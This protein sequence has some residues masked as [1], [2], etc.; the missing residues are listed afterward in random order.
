MTSTIEGE[1]GGL[2]APLLSPRDNAATSPPTQ[3]A[4]G[5]AFNSWA[6]FG[7]FGGLR[8][9]TAKTPNNGAKAQP[10]DNADAAATEAVAPEATSSSQLDS[11]SALALPAPPAGSGIRGGA[12]AGSSS[13]A[14]RE[15]VR[16]CFRVILLI[17]ILCFWT[18]IFLEV[19]NQQIHLQ[20]LNNMSSCCNNLRPY[21]VLKLHGAGAHGSGAAGQP[22]GT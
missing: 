2:Q 8:T 13:A 15:D 9:G 20:H 6:S 4:S 1:T 18:S 22:G 17:Q 7:G 19:D 10:A 21:S 14:L 12:S 16:V 11:G 3:G 5:R